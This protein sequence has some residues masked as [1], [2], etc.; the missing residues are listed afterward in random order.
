LAEIVKEISSSEYA[1]DV[2]LSRLTWM[3][4]FRKWPQVAD[5]RGVGDYALD[6]EQVNERSLGL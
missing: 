1:I 2:N 3:I 4:L 5:E 6:D